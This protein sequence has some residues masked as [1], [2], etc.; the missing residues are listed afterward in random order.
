MVL[1]EIDYSNSNTEYEFQESLRQYIQDTWHSLQ[2]MSYPLGLPMDRYLVNQE[3]TEQKVATTPTNIGLFLADMVAARDLHLISPLQAEQTIGQTLSTLSQMTTY[4]GLFYNWYDPSNAEVL[5][6]HPS[7]NFIKPFISTIDNSWLAVGLITV[8][9]AFPYYHD[10]IDSLLQRMN[11]PLL[12]DEATYY[13]WGG[14]DVTE[15]HQPTWL[16][17]ILNSEPRI[18]T[19]LGISEYNLPRE[20]YYQLNEGQGSV[21]R[22]WGGSMFEALMPT[23][24]FPEDQWSEEWRQNH[25]HYIEKQIAQGE[26]VANG[27]WGFSPCEAPNGKYG[28]YGVQS[29]GMYEQGY[30]ENPIVTPHASFLAMPFVPE[31]AY[32]NIQRIQKNFP[33]IYHPGLG[34]ADSVNITTGEVS[35]TYL[36]LDQSMT[37]LALTN[38][39]LHGQ[40]R[41]Y[42][43]THVKNYLHPL[44]TS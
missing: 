34:F 13:F 26:A 5:R 29:L 18:A 11:F 36:F 25:F 4:E 44:F 17:K 24:F 27:F 10:K 33:S 16:Y 37:F 14:Y 15:S 2:V 12:F 3:T 6:V 28:E 8:E 21:R 7:G 22:S 42:V 39:V 30:S 43:N 38:T 9:E 31:L 32:A 1:R 40:I 19:Y 35:E 41:E 23:L 20:S